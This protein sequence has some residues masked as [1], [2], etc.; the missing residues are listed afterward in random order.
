MNEELS[1][2][3][4]KSLCEYLFIVLP[5][6]EINEEI[7]IFKKD[8]FRTE[9]PFAGQ[10]SCGHIPLLSFFQH[11]ER[12]DTIIE[13]VSQQ[14][15]KNRSF[16]VFLNGFG[17]DSQ[18]R[19]IYID[20]LNKQSL[21][22]LYHQLRMSLFEKFVSLAFLNQNYEPRMKVGQQL[23]PLQFINVISEYKSKAYT[24]NFSVSRIHVLKRK[25]PYTSWEKLKAI[26]LATNEKELMDWN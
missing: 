15:Y 12:E 5:Y 17:F 4:K 19:S 26:P 16:E 2:Y 11:E 3:Q 1:L 6:A 14:V 7:R 13:C 9:G 22:D 21:I 8:L 25:A 18:I 20:I 10:N 23:S 24:N